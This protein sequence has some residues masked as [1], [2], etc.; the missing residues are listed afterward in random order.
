[1][2]VNIAGLN[3]ADVLAALYNASQPLG[4]GILHYEARDMT[5]KEAEEWL[6]KGDYFD[7]INGRVM[8]TGLP[9]GEEEIDE[10]GYDRDN[11]D[12]AMQRVVDKLRKTVEASNG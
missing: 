11:G 9:A 3:R 1:M 10:W 6:L 7:Y 8:K 2:S 4:M 12:G 5:R